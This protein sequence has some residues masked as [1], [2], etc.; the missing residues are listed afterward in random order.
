MTTSEKTLWMLPAL[1]DASPFVFY[2]VTLTLAWQRVPSVIAAVAVF[3][4]LVVG[5]AVLITVPILKWRGIIPR[6]SD[7]ALIAITLGLVGIIEPLFY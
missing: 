2:A 6:R 3:A 7:G 5:V 1:A 4:P